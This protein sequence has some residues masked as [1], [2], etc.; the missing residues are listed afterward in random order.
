MRAG[1]EEGSFPR[2]RHAMAL[3]LQSARL[4]G[5]AMYT[6]GELCW[7]VQL[8]ISQHKMVHEDNQ[9]K[10]AVCSRE[11][12]AEFLGRGAPQPAGPRAPP[13]GRRRRGFSEHTGP[14]TDC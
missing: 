5:L 7:L 12:V 8:A 1:A 10:P 2:G 9:L 11:A 3:R 13:S 14:F 6:L 4:P